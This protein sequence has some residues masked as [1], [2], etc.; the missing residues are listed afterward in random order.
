MTR[1]EA[2]SIFAQLTPYF[3]DGHSILFPALAETT[4][5]EKQGLQTFPFGVNVRDGKIFLLRS[6]SREEGNR[7]V[8]KGAQITSINGHTAKHILATL[9][10]LSHGETPQLRES[11]LS[12]LFYYWIYAV[13]DVKGD[14]TLEYINNEVEETIVLANNDKW[15]RDK[16]QPRDY[17][18]QIL[19]NDIG[20]L[21]IASFD[22]DGDEDNYAMFVEDSFAE[23]A[24]KGVKKLIIDVRGNTGGQ[25]D[26]G[27][28][29]I[30]YIIDKPVSQASVAIEKLNTDNNGWFGY[31]GK[32]GETIELNVKDDGIIQ[33][34]DA[35]KRFN[36][37]V[38]VLMD[39][40][41]YSAGILFVTTIQDNNLG[42]LAGEETGGFA[43]QTG[44]LTPFHLPNTKLLMLAPARY[45]VR[46]SGD[47]RK[48]PVVP[49]YVLTGN[50]MSLPDKWLSQTVDIFGSD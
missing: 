10:P 20:Y 26:A 17:E 45:I 8:P 2:F 31:K 50:A 46:P 35:N 22:V 19:N 7:S 4:F 49:D 3:N 13:F 33:P 39:R 1:K 16:N 30:Q 24:Q 23:L 12:L 48:Q 28:E 6:Y 40:M 11:M 25:S 32:P 44:N 5:I 29:V 47:K 41:T 18:L 27:A 34:I 14:I 36:G 9:T 37:D 42:R 38:I 21:R 43:N 15:Q